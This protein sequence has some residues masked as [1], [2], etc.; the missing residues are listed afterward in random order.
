M[1][2]FPDLDC[3]NIA[4]KLVERLAVRRRSRPI[5]QGLDRPVNDLST[6]MLGRGHSGRGRDHRGTSYRA[7][8]EAAR[9]NALMRTD[10][11]G[12]TGHPG[13]VY[14]EIPPIKGP[15]QSCRLYAGHASGAHACGGRAD[16]SMHFRRGCAS[17][18]GPVRW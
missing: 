6:R 9:G 1:L 14:G 3:G 16:M 15:H 17:K 5:L 18:N 7:T 8:G 12:R 4:Y 10:R 2:I 11:S 13:G